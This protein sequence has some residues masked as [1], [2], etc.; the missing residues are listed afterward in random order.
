VREGAR[1]RARAAARA[2][3]PR[4]AA[5]ARASAARPRGIRASRC[6]RLDARAPGRV[7]ALTDRTAAAA[8]DAGEISIRPAAAPRGTRL[9]RVG[10]RA[11]PRVSSRPGQGVTMTTRSPWKSSSELVSDA[12]HTP[13]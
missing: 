2:R 11:K 9:D 10:L 3:A 6:L 1:V 12:K 8:T 5:D 7:L 4:V 13:Q